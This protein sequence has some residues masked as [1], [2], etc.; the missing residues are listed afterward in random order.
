MNT[1]EIKTLLHEEIEHGDDKLLKMIY[2]M[3]REYNEVEEVQEIDEKRWQLIQEER[4]QY[5]R[6]EGRTYSLQ[7]IRDM[8]ANKKRPDDL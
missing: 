8:A 3:I 1:L 2:A 5:L 6:G 7:E 4:A